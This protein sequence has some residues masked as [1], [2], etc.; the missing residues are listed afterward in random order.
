MSLTKLRPIVRAARKLS[1]CVACRVA[2]I[3]KHYPLVVPTLEPYDPECGDKFTMQEWKEMAECGGVIDY[4][5]FGDLG[6][7]EGHSDIRI[8]PSQWKRPPPSWATHINWYNR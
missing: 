5:G 7:E 2:F 4:D 3:R 1:R 6:T 8:W